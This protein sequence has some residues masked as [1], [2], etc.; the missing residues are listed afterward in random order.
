MQSLKINNVSKVLGMRPILKNINLIIN[1]GEIIAVT[2][3]NGAGKTTLLKVIAG[4]LPLSKGQIQGVEQVKI[5]YVGH[6]PMVYNRLT[7]IEN[8]A[9]FGKLYNSFSQNR[10]K[11]VLQEINLNKAQNQLAQN[12]SRGMLQRLSLGRLLMQQPLVFLFDEPFTGLDTKGK[13]WLS[14]FLTRIHQQQKI[15]IVVTHNLDE[16]ATIPFREVHL[17]GGQ[18]V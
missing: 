16:L 9:F 12:L 17:K 5:G 3:E 1:P 13:D 6:Q 2:G 11:Q 18:I 7:V 14:G 4:L 8:L 15:L 10:L